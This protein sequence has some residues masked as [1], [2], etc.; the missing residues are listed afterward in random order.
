MIIA[1]VACLSFGLLLALFSL[2]MGGA[3]G[4]A[5]VDA[6]VD[7]DHGVDGGLHAPAHGP[8]HGH[9]HA[10]AGF[11]WLS[12]AVIG[13]F[14]AAFGAGGLIGSEALGFRAPGAHLALALGFG[15]ILAAVAGLAIR[16][17]V[18]ASESTSHVDEASLTDAEAE[19]LTEIPGD[20]VG[21][22]AL[23]AA[24]S[25]LT[26]PARS[27]TKETIPRLAQVTVTRVVGGTVY[28][29]LHLEEQLRRLTPPSDESEP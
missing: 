23:N 8:G 26:F 3:G 28:V 17:V 9:A 6:G 2:L 20:G 11:P 27:E 10:G 12:P 5:Q 19:V 25:R 29:R 7:L 15:G 13:S 14:L 1:Y 24:G 22:V 18:R 21:E 4:D 16:K